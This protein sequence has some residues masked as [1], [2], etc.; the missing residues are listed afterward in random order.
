MSVSLGGDVLSILV[1]TYFLFLFLCAFLVIVDILISKGFI[2]KVTELHVPKD[3]GASQHSSEGREEGKGSRSS[4]LKFS[5][6]EK[7][8]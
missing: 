4:M 5:W 6:R 8:I 7:I 2:S 1:I 3:V